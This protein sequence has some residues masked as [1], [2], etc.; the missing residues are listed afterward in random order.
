MRTCAALLRRP[1][2]S[3]EVCEVDLDPGYADPRAGEILRG[4]VRDDR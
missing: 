2:G 3:W 4:V 1:P